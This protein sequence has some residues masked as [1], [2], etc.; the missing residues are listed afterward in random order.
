MPYIHAEC[1]GTPDAWIYKTDENTLYVFDYKHGF[2]YV[3]VF[4]NWQLIAYTCGILDA[5]GINGH[6]DQHLTVVMRVVQPRAYHRDGPVREWRVKASELRPYFNKL[7]MAAGAALSPNP[8]CVPNPECL[9]CKARHAC[10][11]LQQ[12]AYRSAQLSHASLPVEMPAAAVGLELHFLRG[13]A[14]RLGARI[15]GLEQQAE[16]LIGRGEYVPFSAMLP[17]AGRSAWAK[18]ISEVLALG[19]LYGVTLT[20]PATITPTQAIKAGLPAEVVTMY[21]ETKRGLALGADDGKQAR[22]VFGSPK[23]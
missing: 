12:D 16:A 2:R 22:K 1:W 9:D 4:E 7:A 11:A 13:A 21:S 14:K 10:P 19:A 18:P 15:A 5:L 17:T 8:Q 3:D 6:S 23:Q 20:K